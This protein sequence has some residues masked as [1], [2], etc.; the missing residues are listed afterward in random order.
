[1]PKCKNNSVRYYKGTEPSPK[2]LGWCAHGEKEGKI[3]KGKDGNIWIVRKIK[4]GSL[5]WMKVTNIKK[6]KININ[7]IKFNFKINKKVKDYYKFITNEIEIL[8]YLS[9]FLKIKIE[10]IEE[11]T[12]KEYET[13]LKKLTKKTIQNKII[14]I[15]QKIPNKLINKF[16]EKA[17]YNNMLT[18]NNEKENKELIKKAI[19]LTLKNKY[20]CDSLINI[21]IYAIYKSKWNEWYI[22]ED[23]SPR[24]LI[25]Q[26]LENILHLLKYRIR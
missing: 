16:L 20:N 14:K 26:N 15:L 12:K 19:L 22:L 2:G 18:K 24:E 6:K 8:Q 7:N 9:K 25:L 4:N 23:T 17:Y 3:R 1:M 21:D 10:N 11:L 5:R 13:I